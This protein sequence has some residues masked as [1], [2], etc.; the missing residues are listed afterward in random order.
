MAGT[1]VR[2]DGHP[3][4]AA[5]SFRIISALEKEP[6]TAATMLAG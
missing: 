3:P 1:A 6:D 4:N 5:S 2:G